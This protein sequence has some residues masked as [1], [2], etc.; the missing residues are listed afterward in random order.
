MGHERDAR[1]VAIA[2][3][4]VLRKSGQLDNFSRAWKWLLGETIGHGYKPWS[5]LWYMAT[6]IITGW[7]VFAWADTK[8]LMVQVKEG[9]A[10]FIGR[11]Y[12]LDMFL[13]IIDLHQAK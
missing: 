13:P 10:V 7:L 5:V 2:K 4:E 1:E 3:Q 11:I 6:I 9:P 12:S 8:D